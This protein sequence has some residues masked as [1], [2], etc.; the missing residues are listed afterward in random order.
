MTGYVNLP[1]LCNFTFFV[2]LTLINHSDK[3]V[4]KFKMATKP[5]NINVASRKEL[6]DLVDIGS[7]HAALIV[8]M[9]EAVGSISESVFMMLDIPKHIKERIVQQG[10]LV[11]DPVESLMKSEAIDLK[12]FCQTMTRAFDSVKAEIQQ[13]SGR[14]S[15]EIQS[16]RDDVSSIHSRIDQM[17]DEFDDIKKNVSN[18]RTKVEQRSSG[19]SR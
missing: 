6:E 13:L 8:D 7:K 10:E 5:L 18:L 11:F 4:L 3:L 12:Q 14:V 9:R 15:G 17:A 16:I 1:L 2:T 19:S